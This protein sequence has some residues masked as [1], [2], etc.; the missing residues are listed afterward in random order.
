MREESWETQRPK[1][2]MERDR[3]TERVKTSEY[4][5]QKYAG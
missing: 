4:T 2:Y 5:K 1:K 3:E